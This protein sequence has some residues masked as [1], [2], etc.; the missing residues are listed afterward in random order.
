MQSI[1]SPVFSSDT[2]CKLAMEYAPLLLLSPLCV[3]SKQT[4]AACCPVA[5]VTAGYH[6]LRGGRKCRS[7]QSVFV[8]AFL[9]VTVH[10][11]FPWRHLFRSGIRSFLINPQCPRCV[12][13]LPR[14]RLVICTSLLVARPQGWPELVSLSCP[15]S[16]AVTQLWDY[17]EVHPLGW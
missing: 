13:L 10:A 11:L 15:L 4:N 5:M 7:S 9:L 8:C 14:V 2:L 3:G 1:K 17:R 16:L 6:S 12:V